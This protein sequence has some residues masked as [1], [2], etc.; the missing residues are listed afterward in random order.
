MRLF[1]LAAACA[2]A[3]GTQTAAAQQANSQPVTASNAQNRIALSSRPEAA[4]PIRAMRLACAPIVGR[5]YE[6]N[7]NPLMGATLLVKGTHQIY[8]TDSEGKF[9]LTDPVYEGQVLTIGAAGYNPQDVPLTDCTLP[10][11]VLEKDPTARI[12]RN[13]KRAGQVTRLNNRN[14]NLK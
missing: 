14:T 12:K 3:L 10:R 9:Q 8:V 11:L 5:V 6:P 2:L 1:I 13:G 4:K 7:G